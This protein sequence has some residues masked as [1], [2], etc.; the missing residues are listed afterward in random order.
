MV[1]QAADLERILADLDAK[2]LAMKKDRDDALAAAKLAAAKAADDIA[3]MKKAGGD[4]L[5][6]A[7]GQVKDLTRKIDMANATIIDLQ[8]EK[9][10]LADKY[11]RFHKELESRFAGI[12]TSG[13]RVV[14]AIDISGSM[15]KKDAETADPTKWPIVVETVAKVMRSIVGMEKYQVVVFSSSAKWLFGNGDWLDYSAKSVEEVTAALLKVKPYDDTNLHSGLD[16]AFKLRASGLDAVYLFS[17]GLPTSGPG[18]T[19]A[20]QNAN[21]PLKELER[22]ELLGKHIRR[23]LEYDWN[24]PLSGK[25]VKVH[26]IGFFFESPDVGAFLWALAREND[27]SFVGMSKP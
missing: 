10:K 4:D 17:D 18:L 24:R 21:P 25:R 20:Q 3:A 8:G 19:F 13:K 27:G 9:A 11:D 2:L 7:R 16:Q 23:T 1:K 14:F 22:S 5:A 15:A 12:V 26:A 6:A